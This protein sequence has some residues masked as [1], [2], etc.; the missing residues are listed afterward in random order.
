MNQN[1]YDCMAICCAYGP[2]DKFT[3]MT[4]NLNWLE[5]KEALTCVPGQTPP[6]RGDVVVRVFHMKF[7]EYL[8]DIRDGNVSSLISG[9]FLS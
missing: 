7:H 1:F 6:N 9:S 4:C 5:I 3:T 2:P 8:D